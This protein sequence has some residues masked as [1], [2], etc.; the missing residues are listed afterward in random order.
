MSRK[1]E[2][3]RSRRSQQ[4]AEAQRLLDQGSI[5]DNASYDDESRHDYEATVREKSPIRRVAKQQDTNRQ[6][7]K[8]RGEEVL[9]D[10]NNSSHADAAFEALQLSGRTSPIASEFS[11][12]N[13]RKSEKRKEFDQGIFSPDRDDY[14]IETSSLRSTASHQ[15]SRGELVS[16]SENDYPEDTRV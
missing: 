15:N 13:G 6:Q 9:K 1:S 7:R 8:D 10:T 16:I 11:L 5:T 12:K 14:R 3:H 2:E 4:M